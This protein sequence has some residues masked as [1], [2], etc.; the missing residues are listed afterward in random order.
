MEFS[1]FDGSDV[2]IWLDK[3]SAYFLLYVVPPD[4]RVTVASLHMIDK[5]SH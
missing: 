3:C 4:F 1:R 2:R 5:A